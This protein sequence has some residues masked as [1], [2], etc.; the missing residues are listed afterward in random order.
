VHST[1]FLHDKKSVKSLATNLKILHKKIVATSLATNIAD[2]IFGIKLLKQ[3]CHTE[4]E[5][6]WETKN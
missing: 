1:N 3:D 6:F 5:K 2:F 4:I